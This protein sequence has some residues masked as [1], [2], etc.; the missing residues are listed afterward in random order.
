ML[1]EYEFPRLNFETKSL[2]STKFSM[3]WPAVLTN[4]TRQNL[5]RPVEVVHLTPLGYHDWGFPW[6]FFVFLFNTSNR[7]QMKPGHGPLAPILDAFSRKIIPPHQSHRPSPNVVTS[8]L[9][10]ITRR[11]VTQFPATGLTAESGLSRHQ[12]QSLLLITSNHSHK[13]PNP[14]P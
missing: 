5:S 13:T 6:F 11:A 9:C 3:N 2:I 10:A 8:F 12:Q 4:K 1:W 7:I 14:L